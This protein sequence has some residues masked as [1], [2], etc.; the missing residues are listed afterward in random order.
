MN[1]FLKTINKVTN[2]QLTTNQSNI[3]YDKEIQKEDTHISHCG[4]CHHC[5][6]TYRYGF[7]YAQL[8]A[9]LSQS[10]ANDRQAL[11]T[12]HGEG[13]SVDKGMEGF[14]ISEQAGAG[15]SPRHAVGLSCP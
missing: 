2:H 9:G 11:E 13:V 4:V 8:F 7:L 14:R 6:W 3:L 5:G 15:D 1:V 12:A 10:R